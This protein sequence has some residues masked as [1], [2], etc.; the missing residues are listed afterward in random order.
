MGV[1]KGGIKAKSVNAYN[2][3]LC[4]RIINTVRQASGMTL[5]TEE[6]PYLLTPAKKGKSE[7]KS[8]VL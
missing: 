2:W 1:I 6:N 7:E 3:D 5:S 8:M 4:H